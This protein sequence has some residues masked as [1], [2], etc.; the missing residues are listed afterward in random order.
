YAGD[1]FVD[2]LLL[3]N[4]ITLSSVLLRADV[5]RALGGF[6]EHLKNAEDWDLWVR[7]AEANRVAACAEPLVCYRFHEGMKSGDPQRM[8]TPRG[9]TLPLATRKRIVAATARTNAWDA[10]RRGAGTL[11]CREYLRA[12]AAWP[13]D[14]GVYHDML[15]FILG[16]HR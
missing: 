3:G 15:R 4:R 8:Q 6:A 11:A 10:S 2:L 13:F 9:R 14:Y 7:V 16:R 5:F 1:V 12:L